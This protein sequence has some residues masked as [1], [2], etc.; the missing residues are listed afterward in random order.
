MH[1]WTS[2]LI[3][4]VIVAAMVWLL[5]GPSGLEDMY[6]TRWEDYR[7]ALLCIVGY[8]KKWNSHLLLEHYRLDRLP[9]SDS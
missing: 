7:L 1:I 2:S 5:E 3:P 8:V 6:D 4:Q 9:Y